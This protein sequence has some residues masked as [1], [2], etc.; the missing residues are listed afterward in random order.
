MARQDQGLA[1]SQTK[2]RGSSSTPAVEE[3]GKKKK[4]TM[5]TT[6]TRAKNNNNEIGSKSS[7]AATRDSARG[8]APVEVSTSGTRTATSTRTSIGSR[9]ST[10]SGSRIAA[11]A[12][13]TPSRS[14]NS[15]VQAPRPTPPPAMVNAGRT[16]LDESN[17]VRSTL[18]SSQTAMYN[19]AVKDLKKEEKNRKDALQ[20]YVRHDLFPRW[21]FFTNKKQMIFSCKKGGIVLKICNDLSVR[22]EQRQ[23]WWDTNSKSISDS[24]NRKRSDVTSYMKTIFLGK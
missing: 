12:S 22:K 9:H 10:G 17:S 20:E 21:K 4:A 8:L 3:P 19:H 13:T 23:V 6:T 24:L 11:T 15:T 1:Q 16:V 2:K 7:A 18:T 14:H 5:T